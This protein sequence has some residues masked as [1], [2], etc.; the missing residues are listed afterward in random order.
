MI[1]LSRSATFDVRLLTLR[2]EAAGREAAVRNLRRQLEM[3]LSHLEQGTGRRRAAP[4]SFP[5]LA[6]DGIA[7][8]KSGPY[9]FVHLT[10]APVTILRIFHETNDFGRQ[11]RDR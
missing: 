2:Y 6:E 11:Y 1:R 9:W 8:L 5:S 3:A 4:A 7:W 10:Q